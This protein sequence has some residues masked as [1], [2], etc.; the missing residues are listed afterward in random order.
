MAGGR[1]NGQKT[2]QNALIEGADEA[3]RRLRKRAPG[4]GNEGR[5]QVN[6]NTIHKNTSPRRPAQENRSFMSKED[7]KRQQ[8][9]SQARQKCVFRAIHP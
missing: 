5:R 3:C 9:A 8:R 6:A 1:N 7:E 2:T 4:G